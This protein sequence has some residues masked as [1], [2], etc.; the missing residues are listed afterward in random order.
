MSVA[1]AG[2]L[3][4]DGLLDASVAV[5]VTLPTGMSSVG[6]MLTLPLAPAVPRPISFPP[7]VMTTVDPASA[8]TS[9][10]VFVFALP[11]RSVSITGAFGLTTASLLLPEDKL[12]RA[13]TNSVPVAFFTSFLYVPSTITLALNRSP[14]DNS[15][16]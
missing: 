5:A 11:V 4:G 14:K 13:S 2:A 9:I 7:A 16:L 8:V 15:L 1:T 10:G 12:Y 3:A 6:V